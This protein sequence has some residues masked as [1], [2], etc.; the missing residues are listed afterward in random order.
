MNLYDNNKNETSKYCYD[1][2]MIRTKFDHE[3]S[4]AFKDSSH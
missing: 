1:M 4:I 3:I 2:G